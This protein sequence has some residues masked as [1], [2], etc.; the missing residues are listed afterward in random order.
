MLRVERKSNKY[1]FDSL[2]FDPT[3]APTHDLSHYDVAITLAITPQ[4]RLMCEAH[5]GVK[6]Q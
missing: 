6:F 5:A 3:G 2:C 1:K 4:M